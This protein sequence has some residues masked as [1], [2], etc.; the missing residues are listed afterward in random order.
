MS[1]FCTHCG[2]PRQTVAPACPFCRTLY[3][4]AAEAAYLPPG[5]AQAIAA[6]NEIEAIRLYRLATKAGLKDAKAAIERITGR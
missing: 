4:G 2:A 3:G 5:V 1:L 6:G